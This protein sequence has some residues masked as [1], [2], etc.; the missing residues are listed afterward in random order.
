MR[1]NPPESPTYRRPPLNES[2]T[3]ECWIDEIIV[4]HNDSN[5]HEPGSAALQ[6][7][8]ATPV[9]L[10]DWQL[11]KQNPKD[12]V[13]WVWLNNLARDDE[14]LMGDP[15]YW[16]PRDGMWEANRIHCSPEY[17]GR[18]SIKLDHIVTMREYYDPGVT[19]H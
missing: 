7:T 4:R 16:Q 5:R 19:G 12:L 6:V 8:T 11:H 1:F 13:P 10:T 3:D 14:W 18:V 2:L 17:L 9:F 15:C